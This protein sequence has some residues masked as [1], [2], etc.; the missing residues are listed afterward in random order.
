MIEEKDIITEYSD[1]CDRIRYHMDRYYN[2]DA[3]EI[4]DAE[5]DA[6]MRRLKEIE[7]DH[8]EMVRPLR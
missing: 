3:P 7:H 1:L 4:E 6:M 5:Y 8:P 2:D